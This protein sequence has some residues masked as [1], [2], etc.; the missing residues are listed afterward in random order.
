MFTMVK[1]TLKPIF[2]R[3]LPVQY[4]SYSFP[5]CNCDNNKT[6]LLLKKQNCYTVRSYAWAISWEIFRSVFLHFTGWAPTFNHVI[7][8]GHFIA[9]G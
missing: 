9:I 5:F 4:Y 1:D 6:I 2:Y 3:L 7:D 8:G